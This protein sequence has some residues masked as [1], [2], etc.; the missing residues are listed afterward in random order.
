MLSFS[1]VH[2]VLKHPFYVS[3][4]CV[5]LLEVHNMLT[6]ISETEKKRW[7]CLGRLRFIRLTDSSEQKNNTSSCWHDVL[8]QCYKARK[9]NTRL[10][11]WNIYLVSLSPCMNVGCRQQ[12]SEDKPSSPQAASHLKAHPKSA[13]FELSWWGKELPLAGLGT[14]RS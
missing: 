13:G 14:A 8:T 6:K 4:W 5:Y 1:I 3:F 11:K 7:Q 9:Q 10:K 2:G 12:K